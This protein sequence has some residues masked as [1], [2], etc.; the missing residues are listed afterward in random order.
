MIRAVAD[1]HVLI[2]YLYN[3]VRL[4][5]RARTYIETAA[6]EGDQIGISSI[7]LAE[8]VYLIEKGRIP[9]ESFSLIAAE[10]SS[11][12]GLF[13][14]IPVDIRIARALSKVAVTQV[15]DMPDRIVAATAVHLNIPVISRDGKIRLSSV[16]TIW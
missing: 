13:V 10:F 15:P 14:E 7:S 6:E 8:M 16:N 5:S 4:S 3:D 1:T 12:E 11:I 9:A 2:W